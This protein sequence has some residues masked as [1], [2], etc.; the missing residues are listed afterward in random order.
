MKITF[1]LIV[2][3]NGSTKT[4]KSKPRLGHNEIAIAM[5]LTLPD[6]LF[7]K[8]MLSADV[9]IPDKAAVPANISAEVANNIKESIQAVTGLDVK[10]QVF[11]PEDKE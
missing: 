5:N 9:V 11:N 1:H 2:G 4:V 10:I 6:M 8:P 3:A 7:K